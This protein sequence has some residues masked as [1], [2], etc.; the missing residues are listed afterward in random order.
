MKINVCFPNE[1]KNAIK[2]NEN[3]FKHNKFMRG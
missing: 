2:E 1:R 3:L